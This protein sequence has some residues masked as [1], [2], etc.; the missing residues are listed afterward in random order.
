MLD[1]C[2]YMFFVQQ[3]VHAVELST[4]YLFADYGGVRTTGQIN[5][6]KKNLRMDGTVGNVSFSLHQLFPVRP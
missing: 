3:I 5:F 6:L 4:I 1:D 2:K